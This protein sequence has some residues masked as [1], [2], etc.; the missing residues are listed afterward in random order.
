[1]KKVEKKMTIKKWII[2]NESQ[3]ATK[4]KQFW[5]LF[6]TWKYLNN[7]AYSSPL[8]LVSFLKFAI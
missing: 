5:N 8:S 6:V 3:E 7:S 1:M 4:I 2:R